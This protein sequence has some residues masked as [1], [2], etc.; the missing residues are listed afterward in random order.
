MLACSS[1]VNL[2]IKVGISSSSCLHVFV[3]L[4]NC[5]A[6]LSPKI[7]PLDAY[8]ALTIQLTVEGSQAFLSCF[9]ILQ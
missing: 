6:L 7:Q 3:P 2:V 9:V 4:W 5:C 8:C 1:R